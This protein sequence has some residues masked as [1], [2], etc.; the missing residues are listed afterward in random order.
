MVTKLT[1]TLDKNVIEQAKKFAAD[2]GNSLSEL[3]E[4]YF[5]LL[6]EKDDLQA[7]PKESK[8]VQRL[9]GILKTSKSIDYKTILE[10]EILKKHG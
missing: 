4:N 1:L 10:E 9:K 5:K 3:V 2:H 7:L 8:R 6:V